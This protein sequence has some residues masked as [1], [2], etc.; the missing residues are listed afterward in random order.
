MHACSTTD[1]NVNSSATK[2]TSSPRVNLN[3]TSVFSTVPESMMFAKESTDA[4]MTIVG[5]AVSATK[6]H[7]PSVKLTSRARCLRAGLSVRRQGGAGSP[8]ITDKRQR[9]IT[10]RIFEHCGP[11]ID[12]AC[13]LP[14]A[15]GQFEKAA[16]A[17]LQS[18]QRGRV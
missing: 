13:D 8:G 11:C 14:G 3:T 7:Q 1:A 17:R 6:G 10:V 18:T 12:R 5:A 16:F 15:F 2:P 9:R 4:E